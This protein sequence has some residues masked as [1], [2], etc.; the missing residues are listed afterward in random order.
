MGEPETKWWKATGK[1]VTRD[2]ESGVRLG[3]QKNCVLGDELSE[4][5]SKTE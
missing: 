1:E 5:D 2:S 4:G 3:E